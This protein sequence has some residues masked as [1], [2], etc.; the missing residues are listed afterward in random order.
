VVLKLS[1]G[2]GSSFC[3]DRRDGAA[4]A[5]TRRQN[6]RQERKIPVAA[7]RALEEDG[8]VDA[9]P[10][11]L[12]ALETLGWVRRAGAEIDV[13]DIMVFLSAEVLG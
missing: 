4:K 8:R 11:N 10:P 9:T 3:A 6:N 5:H 2:I 7:W 12:V 1:A 13:D